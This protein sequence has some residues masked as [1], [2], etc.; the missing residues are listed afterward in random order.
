MKL[1]ADWPIILESARLGNLEPA[2]VGRQLDPGGTL[3]D[4]FYARCLTE[5]GVELEEAIPLLQRSAAAEPSNPMITQ[6]LALALARSEFVTNRTAAAEIWNKEGLPMDLDL[7]GQVCLTLES[8][9]RPWPNG[10]DEAEFPWPAELARPGSLPS[11]GPSDEDAESREETVPAITAN[12]PQRDKM[13]QPAATKSLGIFER[14][15]L[16]RTIGRMETLLMD[17]K[18]V[19]VLEMAAENLS[20]GVENPE[21]HLVAGVAAEEAGLPLRARAHLSRADRLEPG[22][23]LARAWLGRIYWRS[24]WFEL[25]LALWRSVPVEG[26]YDYG[27]HYHLALAH[28]ALGNRP[29]ALKAMQVALDRFYFDTRHFYIKRALW[30]WQARWA[31]ELARAAA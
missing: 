26:P 20:H 24:G 12:D 5:A 23:F 8:Q 25:A 9:S 2:R 19:K 3:P 28:E 17:H 7:L 31:P 10:V 21:M 14:W 4:Y 6:T 30:A 16:G 22:M 27:R 18:P 13:S 1:K 29:A 15:R 11:A